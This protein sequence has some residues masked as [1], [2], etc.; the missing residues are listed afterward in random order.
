MLIRSQPLAPEISERIKQNSDDD[1]AEMSERNIKSQRIGKMFDDI[2]SGD[3]KSKIKLKIRFKWWTKRIKESFYDFQYTCRNHKKWHNTMKS[4]RPWEGFEGLIDVML[5]HLKDYV[6]HEEQYGH[7]TEECRNQKIASA[8]ESIELL[9]RMK[10][11]DDYLHRRRQEVDAK[12]PKYLNLITEYETGGT[13]VSGDFVAQGS[14]WVGEESGADPR[15]GYFEFIDERFELAT[16]PDKQETN[17]LLLELQKYHQGLQAIYMQ[18]ETD[19]DN[20]FERLGQLLKEN[21]YTWWD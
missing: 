3:R 9:A 6:S 10:E 14:G 19:S 5:T 17:R 18:A 20:D 13:S 7:S 15:V 11:P 2:L 16:S 12:Y 4:L 8:K 1:F 21:L